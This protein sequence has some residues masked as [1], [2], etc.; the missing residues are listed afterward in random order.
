MKCN[1]CP[2]CRM[3]GNK[4]S[5]SNIKTRTYQDANIQKRRSKGGRVYICTRCLRSGKL[6]A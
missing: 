4:I 2:R 5:H 3:S 1:F 6:I